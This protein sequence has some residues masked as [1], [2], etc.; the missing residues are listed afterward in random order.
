MLMRVQAQSVLTSST[1]P[2]APCL[3][4]SCVAQQSLTRTD[5]I[6]IF[7][8]FLRQ[9][10]RYPNPTDP[11]NGDAAAVLLKEPERYKEKVKGVTLVLLLAYVCSYS[12]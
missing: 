10:L 9:L 7:E 4:N 2:G 12:N 1:R 11:L 6:N 5:L 8:V 3:V